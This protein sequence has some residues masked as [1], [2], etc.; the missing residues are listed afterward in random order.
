M[1]M[2][3]MT[4]R[5]WMVAVAIIGLLLEV[6]VLW[7]RSEHYRRLA[8]YH[9]RQE[10]SIKPWFHDHVSQLGVL[11]WEA[12][13]WRGLA[14]QYRRELDQAHRAL[15]SKI[16]AGLSTSQQE[17]REPWYWKMQADEADWR[18]R[19]AESRIA[20]F[21]AGPAYH[22]LMRARYERAA[23]HPWESV[24]I[25]PVPWDI[26]RTGEEFHPDPPPP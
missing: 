9:A 10:N 25:E 18:V 16:A 7:Q 11:K 2:P 21:E 15:D 17:Q 24:K 14:E 8:A 23:A 26:Y 5:R 3:R 6:W 4:T 13:H 20:Y 19:K 22:R 12:L 1:R